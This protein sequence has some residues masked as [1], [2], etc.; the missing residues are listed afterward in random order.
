M[1]IT[2]KD[3]ILLCCCHCCTLDFFVCSKCTLHYDRQ[4]MKAP[5]SPF[6]IQNIF[7]AIEISRSSGCYISCFKIIKAI[8]NDNFGLPRCW[9]IIRRPPGHLPTSLATEKIYSSREESKLVGARLKIIKLFWTE[10]ITRNNCVYSCSILIVPLNLLAHH[11]N[12]SAAS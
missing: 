5:V 8:K 2:K 10:M 1:K 6:T 11:I 9:V 3:A 7:N 4:N 12:Y